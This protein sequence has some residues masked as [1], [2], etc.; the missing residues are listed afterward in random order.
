MTAAQQAEPKDAD[1]QERERR[2]FRAVDRRTWCLHRVAARDRRSGA[3]LCACLRQSDTLPNELHG[4]A[5]AS[6]YSPAELLGNA[7]LRDRANRHD[8]RRYDTGEA[9]GQVASREREVIGPN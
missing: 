9:K 2:W 3:S 7:A 8:C 5:D 6:G 1:A 4:G